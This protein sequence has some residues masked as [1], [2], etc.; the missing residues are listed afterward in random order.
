M[1]LAHRGRTAETAR[2]PDAVTGDADVLLD[3]EFDRGLLYLVLEN[4]GD[5]AA[6][7][8]RVRFEAPLTGLGGERRIERLQRV[9]RLLRLAP[10]RRAGARRIASR[11]RAGKA[12][13]MIGSC[14]VIT[15]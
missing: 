10:R 12:R 2:V 11:L 9:R 5:G 8:V 7:A 13:R 1:G 14:F 15:P 3:V 6:H 4:L